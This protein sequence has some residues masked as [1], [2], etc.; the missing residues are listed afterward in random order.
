MNKEEF[1]KEL[2]GLEGEECITIIT[3]KDEYTIEDGSCFLN[4]TEGTYMSQLLG[5]VAY[6]QET[7]YIGNDIYKYITNTLNETIEEVTI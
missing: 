2:K 7:S 6:P 1:L 3:D 4:G 5:N